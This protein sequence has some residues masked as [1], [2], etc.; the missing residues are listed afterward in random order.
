MATEAEVAKVVEEAGIP[1]LDFST[2]PHQ[3][4]WLGIFLVAIFIVV[5]RIALPRIGEIHSQRERRIQTDLD[6]AQRISEESQEIENKIEA[7]LAETKRYSEKKAGEARLEIQKLKADAAEKAERIIKSE[8]DSSSK[9]IEEL[10]SQSLESIKAIAVSTASE[11]VNTIIPNRGI[12][13]QISEE[14]DSQLG[15]F[16]G[17]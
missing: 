17:E 16:K 15:G 11:I 9:R 5:R 14:V 12:G 2:F 6:E 1:Q 3:I 10:K 7:S 8:T 4:F 13:D